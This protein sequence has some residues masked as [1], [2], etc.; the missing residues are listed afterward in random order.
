MKNKLAIERVFILFVPWLLSLALSSNYE[1]SYF[2][3]W[4]G[5]F[6]ILFL[7]LT[8]WVKPLPCDLT[9]SEQ[10]M[11]PIFLVQIIFAGYMACTSI[12]YFMDA[13]GYQDFKKL[14][15]V[16]PDQARVQLSAQC[17]RFY[18][19]GHAAFVTGI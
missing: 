14:S 5:S 15:Y 3:A 18:C 6:L 19:L 17:Q 13:L 16:L 9:V 7:L 2:I 12:F 11:R 8:G 4:L 10:L 1:L